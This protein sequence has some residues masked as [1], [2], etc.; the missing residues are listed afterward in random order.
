[1]EMGIT[2]FLNKLTDLPDFSQI[3]R[4]NGISSSF[5]FIILIFHYFSIFL[6]LSSCLI[7]YL[8]PPRNVTTFSSSCYTRIWPRPNYCRSH[9]L[10]IPIFFF[11]FYIQNIA[12]LICWSRHPFFF[13]GRRGFYLAIAEFVWIF[14]S[15]SYGGGYGEKALL[16]NLRLLSLTAPETPANAYPDGT[17][18]PDR[19]SPVSHVTHRKPV[20]TFVIEGVS[21][22]LG[23]VVN[24]RIFS[25]LRVFNH[26]PGTCIIAEWWLT[27]D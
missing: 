8:H 23:C 2:D 6:F 19:T 14:C 22:C 5:F 4:S 3:V 25:S 9:P 12:F 27:N 16:E 21:N 26:K 10:I 15:N 18:F 7:N 17:F 20:A 24:C 13:W 11:F 1:M